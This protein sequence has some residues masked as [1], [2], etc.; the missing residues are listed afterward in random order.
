MPGGIRCSLFAASLLLI[1]AGCVHLAPTSATFQPVPGQRLP[2][3]TVLTL[4]K[5]SFGELPKSEIGLGTQPV[6][7]PTPKV[8][9]SVESPWT[10][11]PFSIT[12]FP[13]TYSYNNVVND[14][15][16]LPIIPEASVEYEDDAGNGMLLSNVLVWVDSGVRLIEV[17]GSPLVSHCATQITLHVNEHGFRLIENDAR[18]FRSEQTNY[19]TTFVI[20]NPALS[21]APQ[22][23]APPL[24]LTKKVDD[25]EVELLSIG[26]GPGHVFRFQNGAF[27][28][29]EGRTAKGTIARL[30]IRKNGAPTQE[31]RVAGVTVAD[32]DGNVFIPN[33]VDFPD[34][35]SI[36][37]DG[38]FSPMEAR[39]FRFELCRVPP[40]QT[41]EIAATT[42][43]AFHRN[44]T[45]PNI[46]LNSS[47][48]ALW[49]DSWS[50]RS[51]YSADGSE[52]MFINP[53]LN[54]APPDGYH[55]QL[56][57]TG[58]DGGGREVTILNWGGERWPEFEAR[59]FV[60]PRSVTSKTGQMT[61][62]ISKSKFVE[63]LA[64][65]TATAAVSVSAN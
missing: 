7:S 40:F 37:F 65:P 11:R 21:R 25:L 5:V 32:E 8:Y 29:M 26:P 33:A 15:V 42:T 39:R 41:N 48:Y 60:I 2:D 45:A 16:P 17:Y 56:F 64:R 55:A 20:P 18:H 50:F 47:G 3:G 49:L 22:W 36:G 27:R 13:S 24:P 34:D 10:V 28:V 62:A 1:L 54:S 9:V 4:R 38:V 12:A 31:W 35:E 44:Q 59:E 46:S 57:V 19:Q 61:F 6:L 30:R 52:R 58:T 51:V 53:S 43:V 63:F 14:L 23:K